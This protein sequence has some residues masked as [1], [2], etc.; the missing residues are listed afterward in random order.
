[1]PDCPLRT[2]PRPANPEHRTTRR[3]IGIP[4]GV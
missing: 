2:A 1:V 4:E 3:E